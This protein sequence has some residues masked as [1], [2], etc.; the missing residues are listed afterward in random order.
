MRRFILS[1]T[2]LGISAII[3]Q[4]ILLRE[5][6]VLFSG[7]ELVIGIILGNWLLLSGIGTYLGKYIHKK[8]YPIFQLIIAVLPLI[9]ILL[10]RLSRNSIFLSLI[11]I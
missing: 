7:N 10:I 11:H 2:V 3:T 6:L 1:L 9:Q 4:I 5:F 8:Y